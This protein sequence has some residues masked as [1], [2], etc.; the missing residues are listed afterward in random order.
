MNWK[1][2][3]MNRFLDTNVIVGYCISLDPW[4]Y[5]SKKALKSNDKIYWSVNV[6]IESKKKINELKKS[7]KIIFS[8]IKENLDYEEI[9][10]EK[11]FISLVKN[12]TLPQY[13]NKPINLNRENIAKNIWYE[14]GWYMDI[15]QNEII[16]IL[17]DIELKINM[18]ASNGFKKI[19]QKLI[20]HDRKKQYNELL[21]KINNLK[22]NKRRIHKPDNFIILDAHDLGRNIQINFITSDKQLM[23]FKEILKEI[24]EIDEMT[25][26]GDLT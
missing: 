9:I 25:Y 23:A 17:N 16:P 14:G 5:Y 21:D 2:D 10:T 15:N 26:L 4:A 8:E 7:Y 22:I 20:L 6:Q 3:I 12:L 11:N 13:N 1:D 19:S 18:D 24:T